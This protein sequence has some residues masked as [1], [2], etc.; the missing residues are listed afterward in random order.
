MVN[1]RASIPFPLSPSPSG[2]IRPHQA[3]SSASQLSGLGQ[4]ANL[5][6]G[7]VLLEHAVAVVLPELLRRV[8]AAHALQ[9]L[10]AARVLLEEP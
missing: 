4:V 2:P 10:G 9:D 1:G 3:N 8:L 5:Q 7:A 6:L